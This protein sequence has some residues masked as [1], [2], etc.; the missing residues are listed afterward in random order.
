MGFLKKLFGG[1]GNANKGGDGR[2]FFVYVRPKRCEEIIEV[3]VDL[4]NELSRTDAED[5]FFVRKVASATRCPFQAEIMLYFDKNRR[6]L[7]SEVE[8]GEFVSTE[9]YE[10]WVAAREAN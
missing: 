3:R 8:K 10:A 2:S 7:S 6:L 9:D 1:G 4:M 5:G